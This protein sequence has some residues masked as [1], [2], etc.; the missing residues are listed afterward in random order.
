MEAELLCMCGARLSRGERHRRPCVRWG[1]PAE[2]LRRERE[3][4]RQRGDLIPGIQDED[5]VPP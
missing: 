5:L 1:A 4:A 3:R 2:D